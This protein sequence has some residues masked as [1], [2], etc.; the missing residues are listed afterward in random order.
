MERRDFLIQLAK[1]LAKETDS[2][3]EKIKMIL[4]SEFTL[5]EKKPSDIFASKIREGMSK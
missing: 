5:K 2:D 3:V 4:F 1:K